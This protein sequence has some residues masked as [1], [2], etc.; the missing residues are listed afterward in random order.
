MS[1]V[2]GQRTLRIHII[3]SSPQRIGVFFSSPSFLL[4]LP[5]AYVFDTPYSPT[6]WPLTCGFSEPA[7][8]AISFIQ[9]GSFFPASY[10]V[11]PDGPPSS[12]LPA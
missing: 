5:P 11:T 3:L 1:R 8:Q 2:L 6:F 7:F 9:R 12:D 4:E 10:L